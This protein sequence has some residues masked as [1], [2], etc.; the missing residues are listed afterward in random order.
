MKRGIGYLALSLFFSGAA[1]ATS[2][3]DSGVAE[4]DHGN[5]EVIRSLKTHELDANEQRTDFKKALDDQTADAQVREPAGTQDDA[6][7]TRQAHSEAAELNSTLTPGEQR[8][9][10]SLDIRSE[11]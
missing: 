1:H 6:V 5:Q 11:E 8:S 7:E 9:V 10:E 2:E 4:V 3:S